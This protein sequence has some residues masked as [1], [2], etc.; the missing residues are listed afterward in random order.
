MG[1]ANAIS[2]PLN[3]FMTVLYNIPGVILAFTVHEFM[4]AFVA[5]RLGD[6]TPRNQGRL[7]LNPREHLDPLGMVLLLVA[8]FGWARPVQVTPS[9]FR[10]PRRDDIL[11]SVAGPLSNLVL[12]LVFFPVMFFAP[13][14]EWF[15][16]FVSSAYY[17]NLTLFFLN[18]LPIPPLDGYHIV[19][20]LFGRRNIK[21][22]WTYERYGFVVLIALS[23]L[24]I[25][26]RIITYGSTFITIGLFT[27]V[28]LIMV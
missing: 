20:G 7:T 1:I 24:G 28:Q 9:Y 8:G 16:P 18:L 5:V 6:P 12:A 11:V 25:L 13:L 14:P 26:G 27:L 21:F 4:H 17:I 22:F 2:N 3:F 23:F 10:H 15:A 19:K